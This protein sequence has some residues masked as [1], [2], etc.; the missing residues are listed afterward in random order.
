MVEC[1]VDGG[2]SPGPYPI[3]WK[4]R[5]SGLSSHSLRASFAYRASK[6]LEN[7]ITCHFR[8]LLDQGIVSFVMP[9]RSLRGGFIVLSLWKKSGWRLLLSFT[10]RL[11]ESGS[12]AGVL[13][14]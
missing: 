13:Y 5:I 14:L 2:H 1:L 11:R 9:Y 8:S 10:D 4:H 7:S 6:V 12:L 3:L